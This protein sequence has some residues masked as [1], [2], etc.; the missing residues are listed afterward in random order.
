MMNPIRFGGIASGLDTESLVKQLVSAERLKV[1]RFSQ[2]KIWETWRQEA[3][4]RTNKTMANFIVDS[5]KK[6]ELTRVTSTGSLMANSYQNMSWVNKATSSNEGAFNVSATASASPGT[7]EMKVNKLATGVTLASGSN[8][9][10]DTVEALGFG[11]GTKIQINGKEITLAKT[12]TLSQVAT[13]IR[14]ETGLN[15]RFD[16]G[17]KRFFLSTTDTGSNA[18]IEFGNSG[19]TAQEIELDQSTKNFLSALNFDLTG[20]TVENRKITLE[21]EE[22]IVPA[23]VTNLS[24]KNIKLNGVEIQIVEEDTL[25]QI[26]LKI[27]GIEGI[28]AS[29]DSDSNK[30]SI[31]ASGSGSTAKI[32]FADDDDT[33]LFLETLKLNEAN[34]IVEDR[35]VTFQ[36]QKAEIEFQGAII[37][38]DSN[39]INILGMSI[40]LTSTTSDFERITVS[41]DI[42]G[43][44]DKIKEF[45]EEYNNIVEMMNLSLSEKQYRDFKP[46][47]DEQRKAMGEEEAKLWD[48]KAKSGLLRGDQTVNRVLQT[49]RTGLYEE[50]RD[51]DSSNFGAAG[52]KV[53]SLFE[54]G[55]TTG[56]FR[57]G[58]KLVIDEDKLRAALRDDPD[59]VIKTLFKS[60][61]IS[62][63]TINSSDSA[64]VRAEKMKQNAAR[65]ADTGVFSR[66]YDD[67][68]SGMKNIID[69]S[70][71]GNEAT[72]LRSVR[73]NIM[74]DY[75]TKGSKSLIDDRINDI[76]KRIDRE[77]IRIAGLEERY[78]R[79][80]TALEKAMSQMNNQSAWL[81][82]QFSSN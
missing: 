80:F 10:G 16:A 60:S 55:I 29:F 81:T 52:T 64:E 7:Y 82:Q 51:M 75:V 13:K 76:D 63:A 18:K 54:F 14:N 35:K 65:R 2:Q 42:D 32:E 45:V 43:A 4:N 59:K 36:G 27:T 23:E 12:D 73:S 53:G 39:N 31:N 8:I 58:G 67:M 71:P 30:F 25:E 50:V 68:I 34:K 22:A 9:N 79:Q 28:E 74:I 37:E 56:N 49:M 47:T 72:L 33:K 70:G 48:E 20:G 24:G 69:Q 40:N 62:E 17:S 77:N 61:S 3:F 15:A 19:G 1:D 44:V 6:L 41:T 21:S 38:Y 78:W 26:A 11:D 66:L 57:D 46:L 5:R